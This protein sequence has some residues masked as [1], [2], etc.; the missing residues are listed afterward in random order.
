MFIYFQQQKYHGEN[1]G[2]SR[3][4]LLQDYQ[5]EKQNAVKQFEQKHM[6]NWIIQN[7]MKSITPQQVRTTM[8]I[9]PGF[10]IVPLSDEL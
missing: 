7:V 3:S 5:V 4:S 1:S 2:E 6:V 10:F 9:I 8:Y